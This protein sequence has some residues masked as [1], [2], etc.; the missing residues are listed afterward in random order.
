MN[1]YKTF[2]TDLNQ[3]DRAETAF[4]CTF[5]AAV[6]NLYYNCWIKLSEKDIDIIAKKQADKWLFD[7]KAGWSSIQGYNAVLQYIID[8][9]KA[10]KIEKIPKLLKLYDEKDIKEYLKN[11]YMIT[12]WIKVD[13]KKFIEDIKDW[14]IDTKDYKDLKWTMWHFLNFVSWDAEWSW[15]Y[16]VDNYFF[17][18]NWRPNLYKAN[19]KEL[20]ED[21]DQTTKFVFVF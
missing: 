6:M 15:I 19:L 12:T 9:Q 2:N 14:K 1:K 11:D 17:N 21:I 7:Y 10:L 13:Y 3:G 18:E 8:N 4:Q 5:Y 20:L 16:L